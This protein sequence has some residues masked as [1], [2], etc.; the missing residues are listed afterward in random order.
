MVKN[1]TRGGFHGYQPEESALQT[2][3]LVPLAKP[4]KQQS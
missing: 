3:R 2:W 4:G 1:Y